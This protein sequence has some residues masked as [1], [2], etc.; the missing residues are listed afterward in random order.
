MKLSKRQLCTRLKLSQSTLD[1][2]IREEIITVEKQYEGRRVFF[3]ITD[4]GLEEIKKIVR[5]KYRKKI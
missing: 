4:E 2:M 5:D 1:I 3:N